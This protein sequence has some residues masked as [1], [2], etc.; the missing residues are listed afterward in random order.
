[1]KILF[2]Q[3]FSKIKYLHFFKVLFDCFFQT[4]LK[5]MIN[6]VFYLKVMFEDLG[7]DIFK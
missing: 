6:S 7:I 1:M 3:T 2:F 5:L 4:T